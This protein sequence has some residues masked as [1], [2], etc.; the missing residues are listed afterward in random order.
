MGFYPFG[1]SSLGLG[2]LL[3]TGTD[4]AVTLDGSTSFAGS[5]GT[6]A[7]NVYTMLRDVHCTSLTINA[8][9]T[10]RPAN[11][12]IFCQGT[13]SIAATGLIQNNGGNA[14]GGSAG[15]SPFGSA[16]FV[17]ARAGGAGGVGVSGAGGAGSN[18]NYGTAGG[19]GGAGTAGA[20][21]AA[22]TVTISAANAGPNVVTM[23][24]VAIVGVGEFS[25]NSQILGAWGSGGGGGGSDAAS[26]AGGGGGAGGGLI[27]IFAFGLI[28]NGTISATGGNGAAG[29]G[30][31]AGGGGGGGGG[32]ILIYTIQTPTLGTTNVAGGALGAGVGTGAAGTA[33]GAGL[34]VSS[35]I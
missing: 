20:A 3:G 33:G 16:S 15:V 29:T 25:F 6:P 22:G 35:V 31:N 26:N 9:I 23:P 24:Y 28:N 21:G 1:P 17:T 12:R 19:P 7:G 18:A 10:L 5:F 30:G 27:A 13:V 4:G 8:G 2:V 14:A 32:A 34:L 11:F